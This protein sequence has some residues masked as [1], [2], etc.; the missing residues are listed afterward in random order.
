MKTLAR[1]DDKA[2]ILRRLATLTP[3]SERR[4]GK[5]TVHQM[6]CHL[7]DGF[8]MTSGERPV[9]DVAGLPQ[10]T[11]VKW[12]ALYAP[13]RWPPEIQ[14]VPEIDA[15]VSGSPPTGFDADRADVAVRL[16]AFLEQARAGRCRP[17]PIFGR[18]SPAA[19]LRWGYL[20][21]DHHLR[22]FGA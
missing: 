14:T 13:M 10:R 12:I 1:A 7:A 22:Q 11:I 9:R 3:A 21:C 20:H 16:E 17:H 8:R 5:M 18:L 15:L 6:V 2:E 4:W 19:W